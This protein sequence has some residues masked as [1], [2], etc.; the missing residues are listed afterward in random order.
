MS[1]ASRA[2]APITRSEQLSVVH[3]H[4]AGLDIGAH[5]IV[6]CTPRTDPVMMGCSI[7][8]TQEDTHEAE[9]VHGRTDYSPAQTG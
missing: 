8:Y 3:P 5:E 2:A 7:E 6:T 1:R 4:A 9:P